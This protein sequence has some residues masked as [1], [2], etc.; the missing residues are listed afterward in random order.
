MKIG[1]IYT[2]ETYDSVERPFRA[3][4]E[5]PFGIAIILTV[6]QKA[7]HDVELFVITPDTDLEKSL[8]K[9]IR[10]EQPAMFCFT[11]VSTQ[12]WQAKKVA[13]YVL[14]IDPSIYC[15]LGGHH[16]SLNSSAV[17]EEGVFDAICVGEGERGIVALAE[18]LPQIKRGQYDF[19]NFWFRDRTTGVIHKNVLEEFRGD[20]DAL[21]FI[22]R[23]I[24]DKWIE[25]PDEYPSLLLGRGCP[26]KCTYCSNHAMA[27]LAEGNYVRFRSPSNIVEELTC[28]SQDYP[29][30]DRVYLEVETCGA[31]RK[32]SYAV[33]DALAEYNRSRERPLR[34]G[35][36][37]AL[38]SNF[39]DKAERIDELLS[40]A[41]ATNI[42]TIN[43]GLESGSERMRKEVLN[44][45]SYTNDELIKF[46]NAAKA[47]GIK[48]IYFVLIGIPGE[49]IEDYLETVRVARESQPFTCYV[50][51]F[52]PYLGTDLATQAIQMGL[53]QPENLSPK[54]ERST[55]RLNLEGFSSKRIQFEY[56]IFWWRVYK[57]HWPLAKI[58]ASMFAAFLKG[59]P[60]IYSLYLYI[61]NNSDFVMGLVGRYSSSG[62]RSRRTPRTVGTRV[63][64]IRE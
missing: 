26:F 54:S 3:P 52:F 33:F 34:F 30:V 46:C 15:V 14:E 53:I 18:N 55:A 31:N 38:T 27:K 21:P 6:L 13:Q 48:V 59:H 23:K 41:R 56:I 19:K 16:A 12:Y 1:C 8:S 44:R 10:T 47:Y 5:I 4:T 40:K 43:M 37:L 9:Y 51:I 63:D 2:V 20:L 62:P 45:P 58:L 36:N 61:R 64:V 17:I 50:S 42:T 49:S 29:N 25:Q 35:V 57:G 7:G 28:L 39:M 11:A 60:K 24:W 32:A 22:N